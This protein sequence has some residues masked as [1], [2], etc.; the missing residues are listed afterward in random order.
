MLHRSS[1]A[2]R[3]NRASRPPDRFERNARQG[4][5]CSP[6][7]F[8]RNLRSLHVKSLTRLLFIA[9]PACQP[10]RRDPR[11]RRLP[12]PS[13]QGADRSG[14]PA[15]R[16]QPRRKHI[17]GPSAR[18]LREGNIKTP[19]GECRVAAKNCR[20]HFQ[21]GEHGGHGPASDPASEVEQVESAACGFTP[22]TG[23]AFAVGRDIGANRQQAFTRTLGRVFTQGSGARG[24]ADLAT[25][26]HIRQQPQTP[27]GEGRGIV[28]DDDFRSV[29]KR[30][31]FRADRGRHD[32]HG[33]HGGFDDLGP[34]AASHMN[35]SDG[36]GGL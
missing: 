15:P 31:A 6:S 17:N 18:P 28:C 1:Y 33:V 30:E 29:L 34:R 24:V 3:S 14:P 12:P 21:R 5:F 22:N 9:T 27:V 19:R 4:L 10:L 2:R 35:W 26:L 36:E 13:S 25:D 7:R 16:V 11:R 20:A 23:C 32:R 8:R